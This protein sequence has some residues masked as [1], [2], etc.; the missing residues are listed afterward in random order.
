VRAERGALEPKGKK[1]KIWEILLGGWIHSPASIHHRPLSCRLPAK[2]KDNPKTKKNGY[3]EGGGL[4]ARDKNEKKPI[5]LLRG[6]IILLNKQYASKTG[7]RPP[8]FKK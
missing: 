7:T 2:H 8:K 1:E 5:H 6:S 4:V 3:K